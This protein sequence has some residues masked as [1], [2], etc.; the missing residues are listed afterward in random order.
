MSAGAVE[1]LTFI[2]MCM[3]FTLMLI[4]LIIHGDSKSRCVD[5]KINCNNCEYRRKQ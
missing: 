5:C 2:A 1:V 3:V 4:G